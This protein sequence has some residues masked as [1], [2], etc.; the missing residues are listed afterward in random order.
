MDIAI[1]TANSVSYATDMVRFF[2]AIS[3]SSSAM[4]MLTGEASRT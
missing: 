4:R 2:A 3:A 1:V